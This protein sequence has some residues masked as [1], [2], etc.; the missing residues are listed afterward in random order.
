MRIDE[1]IDDVLVAV[2]GG[3]VESCVTLE[4]IHSIMVC[5]HNNIM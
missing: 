5:S 4:T 1:G 2:D 3:E